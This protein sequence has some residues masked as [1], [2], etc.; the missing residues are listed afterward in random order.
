M[1][2]RHN[3]RIMT[4]LTAV[5][6]VTNLSGAPKPKKEVY[7]PM[8]YSTCGYHASENAIPNVPVSIYVAPQQGDCSGIIQQAVDYVS[9][10]KP[11]KNGYRGCVLLGE[12]IFNISKAIRITSSG[13]V[14]RGVDKHKTSIK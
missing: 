14:L 8:D 2:K 13:V 1:R 3:F 6:M 5:C 4:L 9:Q 7:I 12:G 11:D 10:L